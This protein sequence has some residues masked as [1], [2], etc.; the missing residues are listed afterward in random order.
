MCLS[1]FAFIYNITQTISFR[2]ESLKV[3]FQD[4]SHPIKVWIPTGG[5]SCLLGRTHVPCKG[6]RLKESP[7][8]L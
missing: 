8:S 3:A 6:S 1:T 5:I 7:L 4:V 2:D